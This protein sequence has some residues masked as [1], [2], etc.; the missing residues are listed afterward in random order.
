MKPLGAPAL[1]FPF[2]AVTWILLLATYGFAGLWGVGLP[3]EGVVSPFEPAVTLAAGP[4]AFATGVV[5]S[6]GQVFLKASVASG[7]LMLLGLA[8]SSIPAALMA[9]GGA[10]LAVAAAHAFGAEGDIEGCGIGR[11]DA[12]DEAVGR[13]AGFALI[14]RDRHAV[15]SAAN[16]AARTNQIAWRRLSLPHPGRACARPGTGSCGED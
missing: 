6:I 7:L 14:G 2:V 16:L 4:G 11:D 8:V 13:G 3:A 10:I 12:E 1:T 15:S 5:L 9:L